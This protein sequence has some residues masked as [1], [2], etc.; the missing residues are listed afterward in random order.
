M[1]IIV[2]NVYDPSEKRDSVDWEIFMKV[3]ISLFCDLPC[4]SK[5]KSIVKTDH[6]FS[7]SVILK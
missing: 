3:L 6:Y 5:I 1:Y 4:V 7:L 2:I